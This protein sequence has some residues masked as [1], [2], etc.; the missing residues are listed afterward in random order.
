M[1][2]LESKKTFSPLEIIAILNITLQEIKLP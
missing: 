2:K 1:N